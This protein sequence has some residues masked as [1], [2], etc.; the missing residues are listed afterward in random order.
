MSKAK[1]ALPVFN[2][3]SWEEAKALIADL[4]KR[5]AAKKAAKKSNS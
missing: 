1:K 3:P 5:D 4:E 2:P